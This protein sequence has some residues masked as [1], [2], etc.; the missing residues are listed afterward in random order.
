MD[1]DRVYLDTSGV[2]AF[3]NAVD[4]FHRK[5]VSVWELVLSNGACFVMTDYVRL[6]TWSLVQRRL[7]TEAV[8]DFRARILP[9]CSIVVVGEDGFNRLAA[10]CHLMR[11][12]ELSLVDLSSFD[13]MRSEGLTHA[14]AFDKHFTEQGFITPESP[15]WKFLSTP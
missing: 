7:G 12:R 3:L 1:G 2:L 15:L 8:E 4:E 6:E 9:L 13:C 5:A 14:L 11:R 10:Q